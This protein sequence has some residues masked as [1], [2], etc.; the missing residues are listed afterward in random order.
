MSNRRNLE[1]AIEAR[2]EAEVERRVEAEVERRVEAEVERIIERMKPPMPRPAQ[3]PDSLLMD[4]RL[5]PGGRKLYQWRA[6]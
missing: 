4:P 3:V 2:V 6:G 1:T 5:Q